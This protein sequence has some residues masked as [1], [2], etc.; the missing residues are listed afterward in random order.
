MKHKRFTQTGWFFIK[1][2]RFETR[3]TRLTLIIETVMK[4]V[5]FLLSQ[6]CVNSVENR[7]LYLKGTNPGRWFGSPGYRAASVG[8]V[9]HI[10]NFRIKIN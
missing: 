9:S 8:L 10:P 7:G 1:R 3:R 4:S 5:V 2:C 6:D